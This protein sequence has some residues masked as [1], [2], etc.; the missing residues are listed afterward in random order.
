[1]SQITARFQNIYRL[2]DHYF[3]IIGCG[4]IGSF[5]AMNLARAGAENF[6]L[7]DHDT[8]DS[9]NI[10][11]QHYD[12]SHI[13]NSKV[14]MLQKQME[15]INP[16]LNIKNKRDKYDASVYRQG[17]YYQHI[18]N[19][20]E[21][22]TFIIIGVDSMHARYDIVNNICSKM[23]LGNVLYSE[24]DLYVLDA[25]MGSE[26]FQ[27]Y[28]WQVWTDEFKERYVATE[29]NGRDLP[30]HERYEVRRELLKEVSIAFREKYLET[31]YDDESGD[32][33]PCNARST[34]Y[35]ASMAGSFINNQIR[36][37]VDTSSPTNTNVVFNFPAMM[38]KCDT[39]Y[40]VLQQTQTNQ[41]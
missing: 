30:P 22:K 24:T 28:Q 3:E 6:M 27:M 40:N 12:L 21:K 16:S 20:F 10:G 8:V 15:A 35:C 2:Q 23:T 26:T 18:P 33:E 14:K 17:F 9:V 7:W 36:K 4:A 31:W 5:T 25:R 37:I 38:L 19:E 11:V 32:S 1:M 41:T 29:R 34:N 39:D 13:G